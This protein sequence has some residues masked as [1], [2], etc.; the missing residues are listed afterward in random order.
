M[1]HVIIKEIIALALL[2]IFVAMFY[3]V[4]PPVAYIAT[5]IALVSMFGFFVLSLIGTDDQDERQH[6]HRS[7]AAEAAFITGGVLLLVGIAHQVFVMQ[8]TDPWLF[9]VLVTMMLVRLGVR[10]YL[11][12]FN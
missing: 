5:Y 9:G 11:D 8:Y 1:H 10:L 6:I 3:L 2:V 12:K 4:L 7:V